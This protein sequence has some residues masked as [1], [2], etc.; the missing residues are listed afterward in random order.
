M[1]RDIVLARLCQER[2]VVVARRLGPEHAMH[3]ADA[4]VEAGVAALE[5]TLDEQSAVSTIA[6]LHKRFG[7]RLLVG[8]GTTLKRSSAEAALAA[9]A[10]FIVS[11][12]FI[13]SVLELCH[14]ADVLGVPGAVTPND[15]FQALNAGAKVIKLFPAS[16]MPSTYIRDVLEPLR[17]L[18]PI[19][20]LTGGLDDL[21][22]P[23][24]FAAGVTI[25]GIGGA[26]LAKEDLAAGNYSQIGTRAR[27]LLTTIRG[28]S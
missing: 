18:Q 15:I 2:L 19:F 5:I 9:G 14:E 10:D 12:V 11:P 25:V 23:A 8:A 21:Q 16:L 22:I 28:N 17:D 3:V 26:I 7:A 4:L 13:P 24:Y 20:M 27:H 1:A 6:E